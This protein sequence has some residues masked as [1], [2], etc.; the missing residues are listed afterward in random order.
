MP[1]DRAQPNYFAINGR[2]YPPT[3]TVKMRVG[4]TLKVRIAGSS[5][6][7]IHPMHFHRGPL[8]LLLFAGNPWAPFRALFRRYR[9][10]WVR[11]ALRYDLEAAVVGVSS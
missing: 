4:E 10:R 6:G 3:D 8:K 9:E 7:F 1:T 2:A 11:A 5:N